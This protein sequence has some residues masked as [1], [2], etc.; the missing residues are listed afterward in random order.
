M[1]SE[2]VIRKLDFIN[3]CK[4]K[5]ILFLNFV[6]SNELYTS[7]LGICPVLVIS[8]LMKSMREIYSQMF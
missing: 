7:A 6:P 2:D 8:C 1:L 5:M 3:L 4:S